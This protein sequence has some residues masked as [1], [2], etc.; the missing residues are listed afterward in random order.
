MT[1]R[2]L[3]LRDRD[4]DIG[5]SIAAGSTAAGWNVTN[6][7]RV[8]AHELSIDGMSFD[9]VMSYG[10]HNGSM[11]PAARL[12]E[13][14]SRWRPRFIWWLCE[15]AP[16]LALS[17]AVVTAGA[18]IRWIGDRLLGYDNAETG[19][20]RLR[21]FL[22]K[23]HR[24]RIMAELRHFRRRGLLDR[25]IVTSRARTHLLEQMGFKPMTIPLGYH[26]AYGRDIRLTRDIDVLFLGD[27]GIPRRRAILKTLDSQLRPLGIRF[28]IYDRGRWVEGHRRTQLLNRTRILLN[29]FKSPADFTGHRLLLG[30]SNKALVVSEPFVDPFPFQRGEHFLEARAV[31]MVDTIA[32]ALTDNDS[33]HRI[34][35]RAY[36]FVTRELAMQK[37]CA[38]GLVAS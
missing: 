3:L 16:D 1:G 30:M 14:A 12:L 21:T 10:P 11:L 13:R 24:H 20:S 2:L 22:T 4:V 35:E 37:L 38:R 7:P 28:E 23:G 32:A 29:L 17:P 6:W 25:L 15:N 18:R 33:R 19:R 27:A 5:A 8:R 26:E 36:E 34:V 9:T 31:D